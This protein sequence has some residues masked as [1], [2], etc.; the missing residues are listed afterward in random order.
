MLSSLGARTRDEAEA[1][2]ASAAAANA[3]CSKAE[4][5]MSAEWVADANAVLAPLPHRSLDCRLAV[6]AAAV[7]R[8]VAR[9]SRHALPRQACCWAY[10]RC[11]Y[12]ICR[13]QCGRCGP[14]AA[15]Q[16][17]E[18]PKDAHVAAAAAAAAELLWPAACGGARGATADTAWLR[19]LRAATFALG[20]GADAGAAF[21][22]SRRKGAG[23]WAG[24]YFCY[25]SPPAPLAGDVT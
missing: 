18:R 11:R 5:T 19:H 24:T 12:N 8:P 23:R 15:Q 3:G 25:V 7:S 20:I 21:A 4:P 14:L 13:R 6:E 17:A 9:A 1:Q 10:R 2:F 16:G 22:A